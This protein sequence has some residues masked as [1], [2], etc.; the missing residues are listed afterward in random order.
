MKG[1]A[2]G[3]IKDLRDALSVEDEG[4]LKSVSAE[5]PQPT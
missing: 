5:L 3:L 4:R 1:R 2:E